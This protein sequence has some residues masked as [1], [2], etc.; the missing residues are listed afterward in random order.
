MTMKK[1]S[2]HIML[3]MCAAGAPIKGSVLRADDPLDACNVVWDSPSK[4]H[5]GSMPIGNGDIDWDTAES[6]PME[7]LVNSLSM[8]LPFEPAEKQALL[9]AHGLM[10]RAQ[11]LTALLRIDAADAGDGDAPSM[12]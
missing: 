5:T 2:N 9:E 6:A 3:G 8:A 7:A 10:D 11:A 12:Q 4:D 1:T